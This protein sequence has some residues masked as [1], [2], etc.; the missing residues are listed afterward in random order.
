MCS[1]HTKLHASSNTVHYCK[2]ASW[3]AL[4]SSLLMASRLKFIN[5]FFI[6]LQNFYLFIFDSLVNLVLQKYAHFSTTHVL[7]ID[8]PNIEYTDS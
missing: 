7:A 6:I 4:G 2:A 1:A 8:Q 3:C 5:V